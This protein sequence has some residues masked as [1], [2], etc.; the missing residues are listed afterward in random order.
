MITILLHLIIYDIWYYF[1]HIILHNKYFYYF[2]HKIHHSNQQLSILD[3]YS[4]SIIEFRFVNMGLLLPYCYSEFQI[5]KFLLI[6][7]IINLRDMMKHDERFVW[8]IGNHHLLHHKYPKYNFGEV[9]LDYLF[10]TLY[11]KYE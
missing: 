11:P 5:K 7:F 10:G 9:W 6:V 8:L 1:L 2:I 3:A 4:G